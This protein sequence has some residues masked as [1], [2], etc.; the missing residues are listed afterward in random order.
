[1]VNL[2][3]LMGRLGKD[4]DVSY[5]QSGTARCKFSLATSRKRTDSQGNTTE[6]TAWHRVVVWGK[7]AENASK[8]LF[9]GDLVHLQGELNYHEFKDDKTQVDVRIAE[10]TAHRVTFMPRGMKGGQRQQPPSQQQSGGQQSGGQHGGGQQ[11][12]GPGYVGD[13]DIP[14]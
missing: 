11:G 12:G 10:V 2:V 5:T 14:F 1:M 3:V 13:D 4:P 6:Q 9:K 7:Q 8:Y